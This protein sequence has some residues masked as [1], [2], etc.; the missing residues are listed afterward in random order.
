MISDPMT[1]PARRATRAAYALLV[2]LV[3]FVWQFA[4]FRT[5]AL[6][7][8]LFV[9]TP[10]VPVFDRLWPGERFSWRAAA[11]RELSGKPA[12]IALRAG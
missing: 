12:E 5:N 8:A 11:Q 9:A 10:L 4:L 1:I 3:A 7:W 6:L 2:A